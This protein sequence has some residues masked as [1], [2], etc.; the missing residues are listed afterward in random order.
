MG[1]G[2][3]YFYTIIIMNVYSFL[4]PQVKK[5]EKPGMYI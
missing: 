2:S 3:K 4:E 5:Q 1:I